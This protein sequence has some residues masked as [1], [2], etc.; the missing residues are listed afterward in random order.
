MRHARVW[1]PILRINKT[2]SSEGPSF[3]S[4]SVWLEETEAEF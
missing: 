4:D 2:P 1:V 3:T